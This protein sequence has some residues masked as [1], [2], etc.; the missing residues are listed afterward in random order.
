MIVS[1][2]RK[3]LE[4]VDIAKGIAIILMV[5]G[6]EVIN[7]DIRAVIFSFH[8]PLFFILSG[9]TSSRVNSWQK[10][11][12]KAKK[13]FTHV[14]LLA[15][16]MVILLG[17]ENVLFLKGFNFVNFYQSILKG[18]F[19][20]SNIPQIN[21]MSV[22]VMWFLFVFFWAKL[23][24]DMLQVMLPDV[25]IGIVL[26]LASGV[27]YLFC[28]GFRA[29]LPQALDIV[30]FAALFMWIGAIAKK[31]LVAEKF[32]KYSKTILGLALIYWLGCLLG[33]LYIEMSL[34]HYPL[35][36]VSIIEAVAGTFL[37]CLLS[38]KMSAARWTNGLR[39][40]GQH[41]LAVMC[42]H[43]LDLYWINWGSLIHYWPLSALA[44]LVTDVALL[45]CWL[46]L[47]KTMHKLRAL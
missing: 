40:I 8:M 45:V 3:R 27:S 4:W 5:V 39:I 14:W 41:T 26:L 11:G 31:T 35:F 7:P 46:L 6:H 17:I 12:C 22:G 23:L 29:F 13:S 47:M 38:K 32:D 28:N 34:R 36:I 1:K 21:L 33:H 20:G 25:I 37:V 30:P 18:L 2:S 9:Y 19:W 15:V 42:I 43:H 24:F 10:L 44:R 16:L